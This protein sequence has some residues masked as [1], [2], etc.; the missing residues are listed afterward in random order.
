MYCLGHDSLQ[1]EF[2]FLLSLGPERR[3]LRATGTT[4]FTM[5][6]ALL[7]HLRIISGIQDERPWIMSLL[8]FISPWTG[9]L[10]ISAPTHGDASMFL[11]LR[12]RTPLGD[13]DAGR[14]LMMG[15][16]E[17]SIH[18]QVWDARRGTWV[19]ELEAWRWLR[20]YHPIRVRL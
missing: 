3:A 12:R 13:I 17:D 10:V 5:V 14:V 6:N 20:D 11:A 15:S 18:Y 2:W 7:R 4:F 8:H 16:S 9:H 1:L 19:D